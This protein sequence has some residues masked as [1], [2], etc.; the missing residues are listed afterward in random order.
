M[1][2]AKDFSL[3]QLVFA[4]QTVRGNI[5]LKFFTEDDAEEVFTSW[6]SN[7][8]ASETLITKTVDP[9]KRSISLLIK[10]V[11]TELQDSE[12]AGN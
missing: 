5:H 7:F 4:F 2:F 10:G 12:T 8:L 9:E 1:D 6:K 3:R 11:P